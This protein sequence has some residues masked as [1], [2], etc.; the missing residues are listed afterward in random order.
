VKLGNDDAP[1]VGLVIHKRRGRGD[2]LDQYV[3]TTLRDLVALLTRE[4]P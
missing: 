3:T 4:P 1:L 2:P